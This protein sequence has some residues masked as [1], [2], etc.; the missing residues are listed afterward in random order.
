MAQILPKGIYVVSSDFFDRE[1]DV[2]FTFRGVDYTATIGVNAF[3]R[4]D[5]MCEHAHNAPCAPFHGRT[6]D[7]PVA[8]V[9]AGVYKFKAGREFVTVKLTRPITMIGEAMGVSPNAPEDI[10]LPNP[11]RSMEESI[12][13]GSLYF[14]N[15]VI[16][17]Q[18]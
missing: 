2:A 13:E 14:G 8:L 1:G 15:L 18:T 17:P 6:F 4:F 7:T 12:L 9:P 16:P 5:H 11:Q 3:A 10:S